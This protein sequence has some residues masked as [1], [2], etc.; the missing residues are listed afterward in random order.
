MIY[1]HFSRPC[2]GCLRGRRIVSQHYWAFLATAPQYRLSRACF[3]PFL[4]KWLAASIRI[5]MLSLIHDSA[6][7]LRRFS[8]RV[9]VK[10]EISR[11]LT[12]ADKTRE[13]KA[14]VKQSILDRSKT[15]GKNGRYSALKALF[16]KSQRCRTKPW[17]KIIHDFYTVKLKVKHVMTSK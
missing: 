10:M 4:Q 13:T 2:S 11:H 7:S 3:R 16:A 6:P 9:E 14:N 8:V 17:L 12:H 5:C 15:S 1:F